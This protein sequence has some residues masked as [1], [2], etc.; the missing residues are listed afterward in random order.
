MDYEKL[1]AELTDDPLTRGYAEMSDAEAAA[2]GHSKYRTKPKTSMT[3]SEVLNAVVKSEYAALSADSK[4]A[5]WQLLH[6]GELNP[7]GVEKD[8]L[9]DIFG[10]GS[11]TIAALALARQDAISRW[12]DLGLGNVRAG[13]IQRVRA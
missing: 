2:D 6:I 9:I 7:F 10:S 5:F 13:D 4:T 8:L 12:D 11:D 3:G 1:K